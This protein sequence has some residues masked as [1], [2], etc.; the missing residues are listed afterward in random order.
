MRNVMF[1]ATSAV[2]APAV[3]GSAMSSARL[4]TLSLGSP[5]A[6]R[7]GTPRAVSTR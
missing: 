2:T 3:R 4:R 1:A 7:R 5:R 6:T